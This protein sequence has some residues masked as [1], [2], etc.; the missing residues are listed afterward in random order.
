MVEELKYLD[1]LQKE[2][3][4]DIPHISRQMKYGRDEFT[5]DSSRTP[6][7][8]SARYFELRIRDQLRW[9]D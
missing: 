1:E 9:H 2:Y 3:Y 5:Y 4:D 6:L 8:D 7:D